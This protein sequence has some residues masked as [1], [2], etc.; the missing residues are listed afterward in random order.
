[1]HWQEASVVLKADLQ[2]LGLNGGEV[3]VLAD[4]SKVAHNFVALLK[5]PD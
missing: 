2:G 1:M 4:I 5:K 3:L